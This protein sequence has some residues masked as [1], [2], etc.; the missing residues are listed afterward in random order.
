MLIPLIEYLSI[1]GGIAN[2]D[3]AAE[4]NFLQ[5]VGI[6]SM[7]LIHV[8]DKNDVKV[9]DSLNFLLQVVSSLPCIIDGLSLSDDSLVAKL[10]DEGLRIACFEHTADIQLF[11]DLL[12]TFPRSRIGFSF[13]GDAVSVSTTADLISA[14]R[15]RVGNFIIK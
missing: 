2:E 4:L 6:L 15:D 9:S 11:N 13:V 10:L 3:K 14:Y 12:S 8:S 5:H 7:P 1:A